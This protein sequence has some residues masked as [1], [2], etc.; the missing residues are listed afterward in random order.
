MAVFPL[1]PRPLSPEE[2]LAFELCVSAGLVPPERGEYSP[3]ELVESTAA[4]RAAAD[5]RRVGDWIE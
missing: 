5:I 2:R 1:L 3:I 4:D